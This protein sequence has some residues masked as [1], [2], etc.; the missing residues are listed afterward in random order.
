[1]LLILTIR[2]L[3][4]SITKCCIKNDEI[5]IFMR[6]EIGICSISARLKNKLKH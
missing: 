6:S 5:I 1:M 4:F 2:T 3:F